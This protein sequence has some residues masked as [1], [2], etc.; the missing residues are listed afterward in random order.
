MVFAL[1]LTGVGLLSLYKAYIVDGMT[2][3][4]IGAFVFGV[5]YFWG[6]D[7][8]TNIIIGF[9]ILLIAVM[10]YRAQDLLVTVTDILTGIMFI[11]AGVYYYNTAD[12]GIVAIIAGVAAFLAAAMSL[13]ICQNDWVLV[14]DIASDYEEEMLS[15]C[16]DDCCCDDDCGCGD[17]CSCHDKE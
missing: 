6:T 17:D 11:L 15:E 14:Q 9:F 12:L 1:I 10:A 3:T 5:S 4:F 8:V 2:F 13:F 16:G 7:Y